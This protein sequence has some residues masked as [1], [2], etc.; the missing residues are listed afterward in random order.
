MAGRSGSKPQEEREG[1][2]RGRGVGPVREALRGISYSPT[3]LA[4]LRHSSGSQYLIF[5]NVATNLP[6]P[7]YFIITPIV[8][9]TR[10]GNNGLY[11]TCAPLHNAK[12]YTVVWFRYPGLD[13]LPFHLAKL[14][15]QFPLPVLESKQI[16]G[17]FRNQVYSSILARI[18]IFKVT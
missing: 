14:Q 3:I 7:S 6:S 18:R 1:G 8:T 12:V 2:G 9:I 17:N 16:Q 15:R 11:N 10:G 4:V 13:R 5:P